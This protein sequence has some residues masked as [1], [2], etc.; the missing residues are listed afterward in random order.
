MYPR[1]VRHPYSVTFFEGVFP[2]S[3]AGY[4]KFP[5]TPLSPGILGVQLSCDKRAKLFPFVVDRPEGLIACLT[6]PPAVSYGMS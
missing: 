3:S 2:A 1:F 5:N 4:L 6:L